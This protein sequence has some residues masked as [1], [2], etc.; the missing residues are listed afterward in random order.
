M[1]AR[2]APGGQRCTRAKIVCPESSRN[3]LPAEGAFVE[4]RAANVV[5]VLRGQA[6]SRVNR[7]D[8]V[9]ASSMC[10]MPSCLRVQVS[11]AQDEIPQR[12]IAAW[13]LFKP[14]VGRWDPVQSPSAT[15]IKL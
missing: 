12:Y 7:D 10:R 6:G 14:R 2:R 13:R 3:L 9:G 1:K 15:C 11:R 4:P 8:E 5:Y